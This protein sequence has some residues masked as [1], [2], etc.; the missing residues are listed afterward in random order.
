MKNVDAARTCGF[1]GLSMCRRDTFVAPMDISYSPAE[2]ET[3]YDFL[4]IVESEERAAYL[5]TADP[6]QITV[7]RA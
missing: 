4:K 5:D 1:W 2:K 6:P 7:G 3:S